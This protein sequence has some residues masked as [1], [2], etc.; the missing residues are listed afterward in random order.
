ML[1]ELHLATKYWFR[2]GLMNDDTYYLVVLC[3]DPPDGVVVG[4]TN[5]IRILLKQNIL[6]ISFIIICMECEVLAPLLKMWVICK[7][8]A[9]NKM[10]K[11]A[12]KL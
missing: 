11:E 6:I 4:E 5:W 8:S 1:C 9:K 12:V 2:L 3:P 7:T 10:K